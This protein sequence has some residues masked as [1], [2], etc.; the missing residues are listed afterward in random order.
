M[1]KLLLFFLFPLLSKLSVAQIYAKDNTIRSFDEIK[2][3]FINNYR[4][5]IDSA[6]ST[7][8]KGCVFIRFNI[9]NQHQL[10]NVAYSVTTPIFIKEGVEKAIATINQ[11]G[12]D[13]DQVKKLPGRKYILPLMITNNAGCGFMTGWEN[14]DYQSKLNKK[15]KLMYERRQEHFD[16]LGNS[17][18]NLTNFSDHEKVNFIDCILLTSIVMPLAMN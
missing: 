18:Q 1:K 9:S 12:V 15:T 11:Q 6:K 14:S 8:W 17:I 2:Y 3:A 13:I 5:N 4:P 7:C 16:Q 10:T